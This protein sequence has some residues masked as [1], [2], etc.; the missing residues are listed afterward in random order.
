M[1]LIFLGLF[2]AMRG[3]GQCTF[4][5][6]IMAGD[7][8]HNNALNTSGV[9]S[10]VSLPQVCPGI[11]TTTGPIHYDRYDFINSTG[12]NTDY[13]V[14]TNATGCTAEKAFL[15]GAAYLGSFDPANLCGNYAASMGMGHAD[16]GTYSFTVSAGTIFSLIVEEFDPNIACASYTVTVTPCPDVA[17]S[18]SPTPTGTPSG[19]ISGTVTYGNA[20]GSPATRTI[21]NVLLSGSGSPNVSTTTAFPGGTYTLTGFGSGSYTVTPSKTGSANGSI[22]SF[23]AARIAQHAAGVV[24]LA[25]NQLTVA[26]VSGNGSVTSFDAAQVAKYVVGTPPFGTSGNWIFN[27]ANNVHASVTTTISGEDYS[28]LLMGEVSGNWND[29]GSRPTAEKGFEESAAVT[30]PSLVT[31]ADGE[32]IIPVSIEGVADKGIISYE[33]DLRY[34]P[35]V[36]QPQKNP[37]DLTGTTSSKLT[38]VANTAVNGL[39]RVAVYGAKALETNGVLLNLKFTAVGAPG[40]MSPLAWE[41]IMLNEGDPITTAA[42][43]QVDLTAAAPD[44]AEIAGRVLTALGDGVP[45]AR[46]TLTDISGQKHVRNVITNGFGYYRFGGLAVGHTYTISVESRGRTYTPLTVSVYDQLLSLDMTAQQ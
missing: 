17:P 18:A 42:S 15:F 14:T 36:I 45:N 24:I 19:S 35:A 2:S 4:N 1:L 16:L 11:F 13:E 40:T 6:S 39:L 8:T 30:A 10:T 37:V 12:V 33:F 3:F 27:P 46:V 28:G 20:I 5:G 21:S 38:A 25:G 34:D 41:R 7:A 43:G 29:S 31:P 32:I 44:Q 22:T 26:D 9:N 23:D